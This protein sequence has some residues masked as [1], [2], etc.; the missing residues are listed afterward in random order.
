MSCRALSTLKGIEVDEDDVVVCTLP[1]GITNSMYVCSVRE[2]E[3]ISGCKVVVRVFGAEGVID[4]SEENR[5]Y[6][7]LSESGLAP[8]FIV[9]FLN[10]RVG[11]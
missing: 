10:G 6:E 4:R 2:G 8:R 1:G 9:E 5:I 7:L 11:E 3:E